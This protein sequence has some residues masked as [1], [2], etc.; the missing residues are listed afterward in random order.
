MVRA[1]TE[2]V[3]ATSNFAV[4]I[5]VPMPILPIESDIN[6]SID[7]ART[8]SGSTV[9]DVPVW[10][11]RSEPVPFAEASVVS[12][13]KSLD[14]VPVA[15]LKAVVLVDMARERLPDGAWMDDQTGLPPPVVSQSA[16]AE[17]I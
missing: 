17:L 13:N 2:A 5:V 15:Q 1:E 7:P 12:E 14:P 10:I 4:G 11:F 6:A 3:P 9:E 8:R 16:Q